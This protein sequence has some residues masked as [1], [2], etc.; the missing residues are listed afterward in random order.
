MQYA[1]E[2]R[3]KGFES[4]FIGKN[5]MFDARLG[6]R[7]TNDIIANCH[8]CERSSDAHRDCSNDACHILFIQCKECEKELNGC[9]SEDC[10]HIIS[11]P[12]S[13]QKKLRKDPKRLIKRR[14]FRS[15]K[16]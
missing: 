11:L 2:I 5:F 15:P 12:L 13:E 7:I 6:E 8:I 16:N 9:C 1:H 14:Y 10:K 4:K 3:E